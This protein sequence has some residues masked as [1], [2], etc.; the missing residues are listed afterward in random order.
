MAQIVAIEAATGRLV[1]DFREIWHSKMRDVPMVNKMLSVEA[2]GF[3]MHEG[4]PLGVLLS[5]WF[6]NLVIL[7]GA[8]E[9]WST[10]TPGAK[11]VIGFPSGEYEFIHMVRDMVG[12]YKAC[13]LFSM[14]GDF[15]TQ[16]QAVEVGQSVMQELFKPE[17]RAETNRAA[18][19]RAAREAELAPPEADEAKGQTDP[20]PTRRKV[21][22]GGLSETAAESG[23]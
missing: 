5:P 21:I 6:M 2:V 20:V 13:S 3:R 15:H 7:P 11:E 19:I 17:N 4:R 9:D 23:A 16:K 18:D 12:G 10:L 1:S 14:M 8:E 22:T